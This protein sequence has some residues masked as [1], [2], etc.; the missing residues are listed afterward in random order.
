MA[1]R[2]KEVILPKISAQFTI[3][4]KNQDSR[5]FTFEGE[6]PEALMSVY[7]EVLGDERAKVGVG[8]EVSVKNFGTG[9]SASCYVTLTCG[10]DKH[11]IDRAFDLAS[12][13]ARD[14]AQQQRFHAENELN[15]LLQQRGVQATPGTPKF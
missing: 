12:A 10:Q 4:A 8:T 15:V 11:S 7:K 6:I 13:L 5:V 1:G 14:F 9:V 2:E 3:E